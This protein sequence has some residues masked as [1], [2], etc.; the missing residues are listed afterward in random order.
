MFVLVKVFGSLDTVQVNP[1]K[2]TGPFFTIAQNK[3]F[4]LTAI[5]TDKSAGHIRGRSLYGSAQASMQ[6]FMPFSS[7]S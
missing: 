6:D 4:A 3:C 2:G 1:D 7:R 5:D